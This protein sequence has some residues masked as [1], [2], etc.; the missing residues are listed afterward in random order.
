MNTNALPED[1]LTHIFSFLDL[2]TLLNVIT[3]VCSK[4]TTLCLR[5]RT[6]LDFSYQTWIDNHRINSIVASNPH[7]AVT[8]RNLYLKLNAKC[9][10]DSVVLFPFVKSLDLSSMKRMNDSAVAKIVDLCKNVTSL[11]L[12]GLRKLTDESL[13]AITSAY[14]NLHDLS[15][16]GCCMIRKFTCIS[17]LPQLRTLDINRLRLLEG[18]LELISRKC[19]LL[20]EIYYEQPSASETAILHQFTSLVSLRLRDCRYVTPLILEQIASKCTR[21]TN[22]ID[23]QGCL[24][25][26]DNCIRAIL[27]LCQV[28]TLNMIGCNAITDTGLSLILHHFTNLEFLELKE[29]T[30]I[31]TAPFQMSTSPIPR[32]RCLNLERL[33]NL[34]NECL[35]YISQKYTTLN[36]LNLK[37]IGRVTEVGVYDIA[38]S[39]KLLT[40]LNMTGVELSENSIVNICAN[41]TFLEILHIFT[42]QLTPTIAKGLIAC[43]HMQR[44]HLTVREPREDFKVHT[45]PF[46]ALSSVAATSPLRPTPRPIIA[47][48]TPMISPHLS[49]LPTLSVQQ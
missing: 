18:D 31:T 24:N 42:R 46:I 4:F 15:L 25:I 13:I 21:I 36:V 28:R 48:P 43:R 10:A 16:S 27:P 30:K 14:T 45:A 35:G 8:V 7:L 22:V 6:T 33:T 47:S 2:H 23:F 34:G 12:T 5:S 32:L 37:D 39:C 11:D 20:E 38:G 17:N 40:T 1:V 26:D 44:V 19:P 9:N 3:L 29:C 41:L 49:A